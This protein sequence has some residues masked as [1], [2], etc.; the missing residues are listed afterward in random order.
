M[1][2]IAINVTAHG[3]PIKSIGFMNMP[4]GPRI[5]TGSTDATVKVKNYK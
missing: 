1:I 4:D 5:L 3:E 2:T